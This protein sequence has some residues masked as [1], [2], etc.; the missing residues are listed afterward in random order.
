MF[1]DY[2]NLTE[3]QKISGMLD[4]ATKV[5]IQMPWNSSELRGSCDVRIYGGWYEGN[6]MTK[7]AQNLSI[8]VQQEFPALIK[9][10]KNTGQPISLTANG[11]LAVSL[12][13]EPDHHLVET[14]RKKGKPANIR[15]KDPASV[16]CAN[17]NCPLPIVKKLLKS[18]RCSM[19]KCTTNSIDLVYRHEQKIVDTMLTCDLIYAT[20]MGY[21]RLLLVSGDDDFL[22]PLRTALLRGVRVVRFHPKPNCKRALFPPAGASLIEIDL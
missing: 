22:P 14:Y 19:P 15:V 4:V 20:T 13:Q 11:E 5:L 1:I 9:V 16:G 12:L 21:D 6:T 8:S 3:L 18:G 17:P 7:L 2:D 10:P